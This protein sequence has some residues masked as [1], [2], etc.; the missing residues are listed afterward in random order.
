MTKNADIDQYKYSGYAVGFDRK[1]SSS[2]PGTGLD[3]NVIIFGVDMTSST[4][5]DNRKKDILILAKSPIQ[6][7]EA[8][9]KCIRLILQWLERNFI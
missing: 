5:I 8:Q 4:K 6:E 9:K 3:R 7:L 1:G 2:F